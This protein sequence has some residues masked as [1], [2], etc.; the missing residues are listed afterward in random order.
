[1]AVPKVTLPRVVGGVLQTFL[2]LLSS[3]LS[4][5]NRRRPIADPRAPQ[6]KKMACRNLRNVIRFGDAYLS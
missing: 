4:A 1:M 6:R 5:I 2:R 3:S